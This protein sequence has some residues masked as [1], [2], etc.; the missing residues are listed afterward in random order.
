MNPLHVD[1]SLRRGNFR[2]RCEH[3]FPGG[4]SAV[5]GSSGAGKSS[6]LD[7]IAGDA[8]IEGRIRVGETSI[9]DSDRGQN[10]PAHRRGFP[11]VYQDARLF[12]HLDVEANIFFGASRGMSRLDPD[13]VFATLEIAALRDRDVRSLSG[14]EQQRVAIARA[15]LSEPLRGLLF[16]EAL[17]AIDRPHRRRILMALKEWQRRLGVP[18][19][20]VC[21]NADEAMLVAE[22]CIA[23]DAGRI[24]DAGAPTRVLGS[25]ANGGDARVVLLTLVESHQPRLG[26]SELRWGELIIEAPL[27]TP[28]PGE[29]V[30]VELAAREVVICRTKPTS[31]SARNCV[32]ASLERLMPREGALCLAS[33]RADGCPLDGPRIL[34]S[35]T[36]SA[37]AD[38]GLTE[39]QN[40]WLLFK[41]SALRIL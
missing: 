12:P 23:L 40:C 8:P 25:H 5:T 37:V 18:L 35:V 36:P 20:Y 2:L 16:D 30:V 11:R 41:S 7:A 4:V 24:L 31:T 1:L 29:A 17:A 32:P 38:L 13:E 27:C 28:A 6:L 21:H 39:G 22:H 33:F 26:L 9:V 14:G 10:M 15:L 34:S 19:L 3:T